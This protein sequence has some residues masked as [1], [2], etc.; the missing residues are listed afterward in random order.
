M[1]KKKKKKNAKYV[2]HLTKLASDP[3]EPNPCFLPI[4]RCSHAKT[5]LGPYN[6]HQTASRQSQLRT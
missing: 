3:L 1:M 2:K 6:E 4:L 5:K